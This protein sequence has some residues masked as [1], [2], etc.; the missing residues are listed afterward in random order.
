MK[1]IHF[2]LIK[3]CLFLMMINTKKQHRILLCE[4]YFTFK[5]D[6]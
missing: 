4:P 1:K 5:K 6:Q 3:M 2:S